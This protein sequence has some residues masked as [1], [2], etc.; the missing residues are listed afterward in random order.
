MCTTSRR[1]KANASS[2]LLW[3]E[4]WHVNVACVIAETRKTRFMVASTVIHKLLELNAVRCNPPATHERLA[5]DACE[6]T[7]LNA[8]CL[9]T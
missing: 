9:T 7:K 3:R 2:G 6:T 1:V 8:V 5:A 4:V